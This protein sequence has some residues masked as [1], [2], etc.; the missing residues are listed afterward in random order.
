MS[1]K[2]QSIILR[3]LS[4]MESNAHQVLLSKY[5]EDYWGFS[6]TRAG[7]YRCPTREAARYLMVR[8]RA[9]ASR[10]DFLRCSGLRPK[11]ANLLADKIERLLEG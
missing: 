11:H 6:Y 5:E 2:P 7:N 10:P 3:D 4:I 8:L 1:R 9:E